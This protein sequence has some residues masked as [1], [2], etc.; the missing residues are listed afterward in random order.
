VKQL[1]IRNFFGED[2]Q[3]DKA[4]EELDEITEALENYCNDPSI[5]N[6]T[7]LLHEIDDLKN[8][9][10][11]MA[12][13]KGILLNELASHKEGQLNRTIGFI[14]QIPRGTVDKVGAYNRLRR[15]K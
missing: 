15:G 7:H 6:L 4:H 11:G 3:I 13:K 1:R 9:A 8:V 5:E 14:D 10:E 12:L 2:T